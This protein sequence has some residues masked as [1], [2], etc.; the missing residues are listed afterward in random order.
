[1]DAELRALLN[2]LNSAVNRLDDPATRSELQSL[3]DRVQRQLAGEDDEDGLVD[4]LE[5]AA[6]R[7]EDDHPRVGGALR[8]VIQGLSS[9]GI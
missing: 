3:L 8:T 9:A 5:E 2:E 7:F 1:M 6:V 4:R